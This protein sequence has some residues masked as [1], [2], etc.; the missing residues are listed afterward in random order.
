MSAYKTDIQSAIIA[1]GQASGLY[2]YI[3][4]R[5]GGNID[6]PLNIL[7]SL[8]IKNT[9]GATL[10]FTGVADDCA[11]DEDA[12]DP[13]YTVYTK[14]NKPTTYTWAG[15][16]TITDNTYTPTKPGDGIVTLTTV[17]KFGDD[18][19]PEVAVGTAQAA[20]RVQN[21]VFEVYGKTTSEGAA[22]W[23]TTV[24][25][26]DSET[27][28]T[29]TLTINYPAKTFT[30]SV[31]ASGAGSPTQLGGPWYLATDADK[32]SQIAYKGTGEFT[33]LVGSFISSDIEVTVETADDMSVSGDFI[34]RYL[35]G[36][37]ISA[38]RVLLA[39][40][41][42]TPASNGY[43]YFSNYALGL[44]PTDKDDKPTIKVE[45]NSEGKFVVTLTDKEGNVL[46]IADNVAVTLSVKTGATP[47]SVT[48]DGVDGE[49]VD[50]EGSA[51][52]KSFVID[53]SKVDS[54][55]Y[56]KVRID[57]GAK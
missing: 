56:Y 55:K 3:E 45:T 52:G 38:A 53:P 46:D 2:D 6:V 8:K 23:Q 49:I 19:D 42:T 39:P 33:S 31:Q 44:D 47:E 13:A 36:E 50:G 21:G 32:V 43:N 9:G 10:A 4:I 18:A 34:S 24:V 57:I 16:A 37:T 1:A 51:E 11:Y 14:S 15:V 27:V 30:A 20:L 26:A 54:V 25:P 29:V 5:V 35:G 41:S 40:D 48:G 28:Y 22:D 17:V 7:E 12:S